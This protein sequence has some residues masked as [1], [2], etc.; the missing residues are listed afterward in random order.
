M[1]LLPNSRRNTSTNW[2][3]SVQ[4]QNPLSR[5]RLGFPSLQHGYYPPR[6]VCLSS[7]HAAI[8][9][10]IVIIAH[11]IVIMLSSMYLSYRNWRWKNNECEKNRKCT[12]RC[13]NVD[14]TSRTSCLIVSV[15]LTFINNNNNNNNSNWETSV[16]SSH[17]SCHHVRHSNNT[18]Q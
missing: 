6:D 15:I 8:F 10:F 17:Q 4:Q 1:I 2:L 5:I 14:K 13:T 3:H 9:S 11:E 7:L 16:Y 18:V 12:E